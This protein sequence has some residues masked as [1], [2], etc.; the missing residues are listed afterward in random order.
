MKHIK[1]FDYRPNRDALPSISRF[2]VRAVVFKNQKLLLVKL[3]KTSEY[4]FPGGGVEE[5]EDYKAALIRETLEEAG[6]KIT[7][8]SEC[9]GFIDQ[10]Y[11]DKFD[12]ETTF[13]MRSIYF[14]AD[15]GDTDYG[16][17]LSKYEF[18]LGYHPEWT[19]INEAINTNTIALS[20]KDN[21]RWTEREH[22]MLEYL[23]MNYEKMAK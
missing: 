3:K 14:L 21:Y 9:L 23:K 1:T 6:L 19:T 5:N 13:Y 2:A 22:Y 12:Q 16:Q 17:S 11:P 20:R 4:K 7:R 18:D 15:V 10:I 8:V